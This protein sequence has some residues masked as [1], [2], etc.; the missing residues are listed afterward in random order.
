MMCISSRSSGACPV[1][2]VRQEK[3]V[4]LPALTLCSALAR[5]RIG[6]SQLVRGLV[7]VHASHRQ[8]QSVRK[9]SQRGIG[10]HGPEER[11]ALQELSDGG[12][13]VLGRG[14][15]QLVM[16]PERST[17]R[18]LDRRETGLFEH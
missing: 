2:S 8:G 4:A 3:K 9:T 7:V 13:H 1:I 15:Q 17:V 11:L 10:C 12:L 18:P 5:V 16:R 6:M 14:E